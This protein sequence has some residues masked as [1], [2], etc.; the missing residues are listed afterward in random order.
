MTPDPSS[1][2]DL[3]RILSLSLSSIS[4]GSGAATA[5]LVGQLGNWPSDYAI[6]LVEL[7]HEMSGL[8][9][10]ATIVVATLALRTILTPFTV[11]T[12][13]NAARMTLLRPEMDALTERMK[14]NPPGAD[15]EA[16]KRW[17]AYDAK[18]YTIGGRT[19]ARGTISIRSLMMWRLISVSPITMP[20][21]S[22]R[23][24]AF[25]RSTIANR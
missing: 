23:C 5:E 21:I 13:Q 18:C 22:G 24:W 3:T 15:R 9:Y 16:Q 17:V 14:K 10:W 25:S 20:G 11:M 4:E 12:A 19:S 2:F 8:P 7:A 6:R 1:G